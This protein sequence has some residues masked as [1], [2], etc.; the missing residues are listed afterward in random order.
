MRSFGMP[1]EIRESVES[2]YLTLAVEAGL[3]FVLGNPEKDLHILAADD[4]WVKGIA[5]ALECGRP[6]DGETQEE[7][8]FRQAAKII[9]L[10]N[11]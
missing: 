11:D 6:V 3:D 10:F 1:R 4:K 5:E 8:G 7:A 9:E 2:A